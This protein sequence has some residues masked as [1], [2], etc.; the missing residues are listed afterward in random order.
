MWRVGCFHGT[1]EELVAKAY[2]D[3]EES[4]RRY[5]EIVDYVNRCVLGKSRNGDEIQNQQPRD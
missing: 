4:G 2:K 3:S 1:G 5:A